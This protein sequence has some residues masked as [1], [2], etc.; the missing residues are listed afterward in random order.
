MYLGENA[1]HTKASKDYL[2][3]EPLETYIFSG[4][5]T[6]AANS[7]SQI[8]FNISNGFNFLA[9][10]FSFT[11]SVNSANV[12]PTFNIQ[13]FTDQKAIFGDWVPNQMFAGI[14]TETSTTPDTR[15]VVG[16]TNW[17]KFSKPIKCGM[18]SNLIVKLLDTSGVVNS[19]TIAVEGIRDIQFGA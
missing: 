6:L 1:A 14:M 12:I 2:W 3:K 11:S 5:V 4:N 19:V 13:F 18:N 9:S 17:Y 10:R 7:V 16:L 8:V 15:Y